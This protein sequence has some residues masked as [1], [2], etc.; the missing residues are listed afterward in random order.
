[1]DSAAAVAWAETGPAPATAA[2][3]TRAATAS[4]TASMLYSTVQSVNLS[5]SLT[6]NRFPARVGCVQVELCA[7][8]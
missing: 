2:L 6:Y 1:M 8:S 5:M 4:R 3:Q 7:T